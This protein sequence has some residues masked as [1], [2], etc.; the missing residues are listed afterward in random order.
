MGG[1]DSALEA[2]K[3]SQSA[4]SLFCGILA[5]LAREWRLTKCELRKAE[6]SNL[7]PSPTFCTESLLR[8]RPPSNLRSASGISNSLDKLW[9]CGTVAPHSGRCSILTAPAS[10]RFGD[11]G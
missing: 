5:R 11:Q 1:C 4:G 6:Q 7:S 8:D 10:P 9:R 2:L 3:V